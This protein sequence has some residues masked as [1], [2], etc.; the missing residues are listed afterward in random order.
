MSDLQIPDEFVDA[1]LAQDNFLT[2]PG[3]AEH[4]IKVIQ[5]VA[6]AQLWEKR[7]RRLV[8]VAGSAC[9]VILVILFAGAATE[10]FK[11][12]ELPEWMRTG[13]ALIVI[14][15]PTAVLLLLGLYFVRY[16][17][18]LIRARKQAREQA[19]LELPRQITELRNELEGLK[20]QLKTR[21]EPSASTDKL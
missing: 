21:E 1:L 20:K 8:L 5:R 15:S 7:A 4:R 16:R 14:L 9:L 6:K 18:E 17:L 2:S 13:L 19:L 3:L 11:I 10:I 12:L